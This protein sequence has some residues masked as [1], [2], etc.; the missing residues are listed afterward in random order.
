MTGLTSLSHLL[1]R[2]RISVFRHAARLDDNTAASM[3][4]CPG[5]PKLLITPMEPMCEARL[6]VCRAVSVAAAHRGHRVGAVLE[7]QVV[8]GEQPR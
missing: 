8:R 2:R 3:D 4:I 6:F 7:P 5:T 1:S